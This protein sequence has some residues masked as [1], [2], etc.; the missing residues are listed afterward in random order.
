MLIHYITLLDHLDPLKLSHLTPNKMDSDFICFN[1]Q[2]F[3][4]DTAVVLLV[5]ADKLPKPTS[6]KLILVK[7]HVNKLY[8]ILLKC[9]PFF[10]ISLTLTHE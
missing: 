10:Y 4:M 9:I 1:H 6:K 5:K 2:E 3:I 8:S 7:S